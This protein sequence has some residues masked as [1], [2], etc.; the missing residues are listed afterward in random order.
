MRENFGH[1]H[2]EVKSEAT[3]N[4]C[5]GTIMEVVIYRKCIF[6]IIE[7]NRAYINSFICMH[8]SIYRDT[9]DR[10]RHVCLNPKGCIGVSDKSIRL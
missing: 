8:T 9:F 10:F 7:A 6:K 2:T 4:T 1:D 5:N 3:K